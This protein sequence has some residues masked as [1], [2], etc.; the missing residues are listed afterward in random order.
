IAFDLDDGVINI[1]KRVPIGYGQQLG[2]ALSETGEKPRRD[3]VKLPNMPKLECSEKRAQRGGRVHAV[4]E[5]THTAVSEEAHV[6]DRVSTGD[7]SRDQR[8]DLCSRV[9]TLVGWDG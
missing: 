1:N 4:E 7:H 5:A 9:R 3:R 6:L 2:A 8:G